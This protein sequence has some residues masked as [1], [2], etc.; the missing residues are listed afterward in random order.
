MSM[1]TIV[2]ALLAVVGRPQPAG[3]RPEKQERE[4]GHLAR[5]HARLIDHIER[6]ERELALTQELL[7]HWRAEAARLARENRENRAGAM[8]QAAI[9]QQT[10]AAAQQQQAQNQNMAYAQQALNQQ[11]SAS[12][13][14]FCNCVPSRAQVWG[15][16]HGLV[17]QL[18]DNTVKE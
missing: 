11:L 15:A 9:A 16:Q 2:G 17:Q 10:M 12:F 7:A 13:E 18:N 3:A 4:I 5:S 1:T 8:V 14:G 6:L